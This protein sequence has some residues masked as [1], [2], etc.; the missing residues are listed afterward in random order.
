MMTALHLL[1]DEG[2]ATMVEYAILVAFVAAVC[3]AIITSIGR[4]TSGE[5]SAVNAPAW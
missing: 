2:A 1:R 5:F 4:Q 3:L